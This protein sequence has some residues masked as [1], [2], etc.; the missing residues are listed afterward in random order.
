MVEIIS[1]LQFWLIFLTLNFLNYVV[2]YTLHFK[3]S[4]FFP[5]ITSIRQAKKLGLAS[6]A[7][8]DFFRYNVEIS[9]VLILSRFLNLQF[10]IIIISAI[11]FLMLVFNIYQYSI[12]RIYEAEPI[13]F[14]DFK[15][16]KNGIAIVWNEAKWKILLLLLVTTI[17]FIGLNKAIEFFLL[18]NY[19]M[20]VSPSF[21]I[22]SSLWTLVV[23]YSIY[24]HKGF[25]IKFPND[26]YLRFHF[27]LVELYNNFI[28]SYECYKLSRLEF[29]KQY[30]EA[31]K[32]IKLS[33]IKNPPNVHFIFIESYGS[34]TYQE[35]SLK[36][37]AYQRLKDFQENIKENGYNTLSNFSE[38]TTTGGQSWLTYSSFL[39]GYRM[40]NNTFYENLLNDSDFRKSKGLMQ[41]FKEMGYTNYN[42][43]PIKPINGITVP[44]DAM[45]EFYCI[46]RWLLHN[47]INYNGNKYGFGTAAPDQYS[48]NF[49]MNLIKKEMKLPYTFFY[50]TKSS[51]TPFPKIELVDDWKT[52]N[53]SEGTIHRHQG[54]LKYPTLE[55]YGQAINYQLENLE[56]FICDHENQND[57][58]I[59]I[60]DHQP[61]VISKPQI[62]G[63]TTP[64]HVISKNNKFLNEFK[65]YGFVEDLMDSKEPI[66]HES[67]YSIFL[68][69][70]SKHYAKSSSNIPEYEP[71]GIQL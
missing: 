62:H 36:N 53:Q 26:I 3:E 69:A 39:Y 52:L 25:S 21:L 65:D 23:L 20:G 49:T 33:P 27:T 47:D 43:N 30:K 4:N 13:L 10:D 9:I 56:R 37:Q 57:L 44:Y 35:D 2:V 50:L 31:R 11:Y 60:G 63:Q 55:D 54:F 40:D 59:I 12:R 71:N 34:F 18:N 16:L 24:S 64:C 42:L 15:L 8:L 22:L 5:Y 19:N 38:S 61:P 51:H 45:R 46:D 29:G 7:N 17:I 28:R 70:F 67:F 48:M 14:N 1:E 6:E 32:N 68:N 66:R 41:V 58:F